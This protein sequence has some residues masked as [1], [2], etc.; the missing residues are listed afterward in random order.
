[1][2]ATLLSAGALATFAAA[3][4]IYAGVFNV[5]ATEP[6]WALTTWVLEKARVYMPSATSL[7]LAPGPPWHVAQCSEKCPT[8][9][10]SLSTAGE[11]FWIL[12]NG[13]KMSGMPSMASDGDEMLWA[14]VALLQKR[15]CLCRAPSGCDAVDG[16]SVPFVPSAGAVPWFMPP[17]YPEERHQD[18]RHAVDGE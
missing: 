15:L 5:A 6:H 7:R 2:R 16:W 8:A 17:W 18:E 1:V 9:D 4:V 13:I 14:T 12:K 10:T 11:L 3:A